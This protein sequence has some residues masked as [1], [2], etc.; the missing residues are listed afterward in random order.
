MTG[1]SYIYRILLCV[2]L[3]GA[4]QTTLASTAV[5][6]RDE[7]LVVESR[8]IVTGKVMEV[9][10]GLD[11][12]KGVVFTYVRL[13]VET[14]LKGQI[15]ESEVVLKELGGETSEFGTMIFGMPAFE[16]GQDVFLYLN[17][18]PDGSLRV[19][20][21]FLGKFNITPN[22]LTGR[23]EV[24][25]QEEG[26]SVEIMRSSVDGTTDRSDFEAYSARIISLVEANAERAHRFEET[27]YAG[28]PVLTVPRGFDGEREN[29]R[30]NWALLNPNRPLRWFEPDAN[31]DVVFYV[32]PAGAPAWDYQDDIRQALK[33][34]SSASGVNIRAILVGTTGGCGAQTADGKNTISFNNCDGFFAPSS[35]CSGLL[36]VGGIVRYSTSDT[37]TVSGM[38]FYRGIEANVSF[39]PFAL[40]NYADRCQLQESLT[41]E[42]GHSLGLGHSSD[43]SATM[44]AFAHFD[45]RCASVNADD[46]AGISR[47]YPGGSFGGGLTIKT[48][49]DLGA[50]KVDRDFARALEATGGAGSYRWAIAGGQMPP[51]LLISQS[52]FL[53]GRPAAPGSYTFFAQVQDSSSG[54]AQKTF[55]LLV[56]P[57]SPPPLV[58]GV[59]YKKKKVFVFGS[60]F[61]SDAKILVNGAEVKTVFDGVSLKTKKK[62]KLPAGVH[63]VS[64]LNA[65]GKRSNDFSFLVP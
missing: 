52:G 54:S 29:V 55:S 53:Y 61:D 45:G 42:L 19:H 33:A 14:V 15:L 49:S 1:R 2:M 63:V 51:G 30:L 18:W 3:C 5:V 23:L 60:N 16:E 38:T 47:V 58:A 44:H 43:S 32:N 65:D 26:S 31:G 64:I 7:E 10:T 39:N 21:G 57:P 17:T 36:A 48:G 4:F 56:Q 24:A 6:P 8:A 41:H 40:C 13:K 27:H 20:Q 25:R 34:W 9:S 59:E 46:N 28:V 50:G 37:K 62:A 12:L 22:R 35:G 11:P